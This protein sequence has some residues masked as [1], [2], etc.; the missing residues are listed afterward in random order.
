MN[1]YEVMFIIK[2]GLK[3]EAKDKLFKQISD[4]IAKQNGK[5]SEARVWAEKQKLAYRIKKSDEGLY[6]L[7][8][9]SAISSSIAKF[10]EPWK[11]N[12]NI[13]RFLILR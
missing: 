2:P 9:F 3:N 8:H 12:E 4:D 11:I 6:Y 5:I 13:I 1:D 10:K 7:I